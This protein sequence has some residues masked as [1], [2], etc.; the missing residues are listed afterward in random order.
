MSL[1]SLAARLFAQRIYY[2]TQ[3]WANA[4]VETQKAV[5]LNL[6]KEAKQTQF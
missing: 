5:F 3:T 6:I 1:K 2:K 4:P